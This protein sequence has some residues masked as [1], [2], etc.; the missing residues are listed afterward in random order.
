[1]GRL[2][3]LFNPRSI[4]VIGGGAWCAQVLLQCQKI[5]F[6]GDLWAVH[7]TKEDIAG[8]TPFRTVADLPNAPDAV[9]IGVN[10]HAT[11]DITRDLSAMGAGGAV[12]FASGFQEAAHEMDDGADL[13]T[14]LLDAAGEMPIIGPNCY[15][16]INYVD[17]VTM[18]PDQHGGERVESGVAII[19][20]SSNVAINLTMQTRG[21]PI[22]YVV[23]VG[24]Q[25]QTGIS[26]VGKALLGNPR[27]TALGLY[28]EGLDSLAAF[29]DLARVAQRLGKPIIALKAGQSDHAQTAAISHTA[30]L[31]GSDA[32]AEALLARLGIG[33]VRSLSAFLEALKLLHVTGPL[34]SPNIASMSCSG[35]EASLM[36][37]A[38]HGTQVQFPPLS[39]AQVATLR[40]I[41]GPLVALANPL[42]YHTFIWGDVDAMTATFTGMMSDAV[43][44]GVVVL[45]FPR[46]DRCTSPDWDLVLEAVARAKDQ[47]GKPIAILGSLS[48]N[49]PEAVAQRLVAQEIMPFCGL[50]EA[51]EAISV[52]AFVGCAAA[53]PEVFVPPKIEAGTVLTEA[54]GK[55]ALASHGIFTPK[56]ERVAHVAELTKFGK[57]IGYP[58]VLKGEGIAH[59]TESG[60][61]V[62]GIENEAA[63]IDAAEV[64][65]T[66]AFLVEEMVR[67]NVAE[68]LIGVVLD[69]AHGYVLTIGAGGTLTEVMA[70]RQNLILPVTPDMIRAA[71]D[72]LRISP[73]LH[74]YRGAEGIDPQSVVDAVL[75]VQSYVLAA[76]PYE[77]EINPLICTPT[78]A[79][80]ADA[81]ITKGVP[82]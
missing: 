14:A 78:R 17:G 73:V 51:I 10:R 65:P 29:A 46:P 41:L 75:A 28:I 44:L 26:E 18:W 33:R 61:V 62:L 37:D 77:V 35:G 67:D 42:D 12:C 71:L 63:L 19:T 69:P 49:I 76:T 40:D 68:L 30:S 23:T 27:V 52:A 11:I 70:D 24:N 56:S 16:F 64:M 25:A 22:S 50:K 38:A 32:G 79:I 82:K 60:A 59:K 34:A 57:R 8:L 48:E 31:A 58:L 15:G 20:Q 80:A 13:Q 81:L 54:A 21:L 2:D 47:S 7:P 6:A 3:R 45:D 53:A 9:F 4:A 55:A 72:R 74:G 1:M 39:D 43:S 36:A 5:G 66:E